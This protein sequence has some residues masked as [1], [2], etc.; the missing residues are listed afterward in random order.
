M[1]I[2]CSSIQ[3][4]LKVLIVIVIS[5]VMS[6]LGKPTSSSTKTMTSS[7]LPQNLLALDLANRLSFNSDSIN[8]ASTDFGKLVQSKPQAVFYP[9]SHQDIENLV[10]SS[11]SSTRPFSIAA[12]GRGHSVRGQ[13]MAHNG[14]V[15]EMRSLINCGNRINVST[16]DLYVDVGGE[17]LWIDVLNATLEYGL[18]PKSWT[19]YLYLT[20][21]GTLSNAGISGQTFLYGPQINNVYEMDVITVMGGLGQF[22]II[23]RARIA[24]QTAPQKV[25]SNIS[26]DQEHL[27]SIKNNE[28]GGNHGMDYV[29]GSL[30]MDIQLSSLNNWRSSSFYSKR[31]YREIISLA[32]KNDGKSNIIYCLEV[33]KYYDDLTVNTI[34]KEL[35]LL[36]NGLSYT[37]GFKFTKDVSYVDFLNRV[38]IGELELQK[39]RTMGSSASMAEPIRTQIS[40]IRI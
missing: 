27:I 7:V 28:N 5:R 13:A 26:L 23:T 20:V 33:A 32:T 30:M 29:E 31:D 22:G 12:K 18:T 3:T 36:F 21:G 9:S 16:T 38:R 1:K 24:L 8:L 17:Q 19:D 6:I 40:D 15:I 14:V 25:H 11:Y 39:K 35:E 10:K 4:Y 37:P 2:K 34:D